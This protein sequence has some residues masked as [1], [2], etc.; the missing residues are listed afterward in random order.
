[1]SDGGA[2][3]KGENEALQGFHGWTPKKQQ[4]VLRRDKL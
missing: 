4:S 2:Q 1:M 3:G